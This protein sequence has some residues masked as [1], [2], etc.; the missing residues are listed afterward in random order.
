LRAK[1]SLACVA[2]VGAAWAIP[3]AAPAV[4]EASWGAIALDR[5]SGSNAGVSGYATAADARSAALARCQGGCKI[6]VTV[7]N[8]CG[9]VIKARGTYV[10]GRG[11]TVRRA[12]R[13]A[14]KR[15]RTRSYRR[16]A[17]VCSF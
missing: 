2:A 8:S 16:I 1:A 11:S 12:T 14:A 9:V 3:T 15:A 17:S 6:L 4:A 7:R 5:S 13:K 10:S